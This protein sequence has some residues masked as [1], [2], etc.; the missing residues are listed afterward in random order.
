MGM[1]PAVSYGK[2]AATTCGRF[3]SA[4]K[5]RV[6]DGGTLIDGSSPDGRH[7]GTCDRCGTAILNV[8][9]FSDESRSTFMHVG[10]DCAQKMGVSLDQL[11]SARTFWR[12]QAIEAENAARRASIEERR[13][14][15]DEAR[16]ARLEASRELV[17][18]INDLRMDAHATTWERDRLNS[19]VAYTA[20]NGDS[21]FHSPAESDLR[22]LKDFFAIRERLHLCYTSTVQSSAKRVRLRLTAYRKALSFHGM[23]GLTFVN[24][25]TDGVNAYVYKG[26]KCIDYGETVEATWT[27]GDED[28]RD[29]LTST[30]LKRPAKGVVTSETGE[31]SDL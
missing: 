25:L 13:R 11:K 28:T 31:V 18:E 1:N 26:G 9:V 12:R 17:T 22:E 19:L 6:C 5:I 3:A 23:Y 15:E 30:T 24:F 8:Y 10:I 21:W 16:K 20:N 4:Y 27:L 7:T 14:L 29:G 2:N